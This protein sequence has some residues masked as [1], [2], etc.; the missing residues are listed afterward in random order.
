MRV[1]DEY[2]MKHF[3]YYVLLVYG[4]I[5]ALSIIY[6]DGTGDAGDSVTHYLFARYAPSHPVLYFDHWAKPVF[7]LLASPFAQ[8]GFVGVKVFNVLV[9]FF[10]IIFTYRIAE[11]LKLKNGLLIPVF[12]LFSP[13]YYILTFSG[14]TEPLFALFTVAGIFLCLHHRY[15]AAALVVSFLPYVRSEGL[16]ILGV[17]GLYFLVKQNWRVIPALIFGSVAYGIAGY[18]VYHDFL[19]VFT[20]IPYA[21]LSSVYGRGPLLHFVE[22]LINVT[23]VPLY[24]LFW[25]GFISLTVKS[26][27]GKAVAEQSILILV[28]FTTFFVAHSLFWYLG[29]FNSMGLKR[30][31]LGIMPMI[32]IIVLCG[33]N[34]IVEEFLNYTPRVKKLLYVFILL[35]VFV[36]PFTANPSAIHWKKDMM[37]CEEQHLAEKVADFIGKQNNRMYPLVYSHYYLSVTMNLDHFDVLKRID[38]SRGSISNMKP[39]ELLIWDNRFADSESGINKKEL[40][41]DPTL[42]NIFSCKGTEHDGEMIFAVFQKN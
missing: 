42:K 31:L 25:L 5:A 38:V 30:V 15:L 9:T 12:M 6:F 7:V 16:I 8:F 40:D 14:L 28:G 1:R 18:F 10:T 19:W 23:G 37:L 35:Y 33:F 2:R 41:E 17:F 39:G 27:K 11:A 4:V 3:F 26:I 13:L 22:Q 20:K 29:I 24:A 32:A 36:F 21:K 34:V